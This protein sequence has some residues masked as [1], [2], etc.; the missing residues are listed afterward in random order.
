MSITGPGVEEVLC[1]GE[2][3]GRK[4]GRDLE[5]LGGPMRS[6]SSDSLDR[7]VARL[8]SPAPIPGPGVLSR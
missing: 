3:E 1:R 7:A 4:E 8:I 5:G 2:E 6:S